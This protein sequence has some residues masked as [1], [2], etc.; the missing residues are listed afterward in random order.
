[1]T[2]P[3]RIDRAETIFWSVRAYPIEARET[4]LARECGADAELRAMVSSLLELDTVDL[5]RFLPPREVPLDPQ[6]DLGPTLG[7][8]QLV[9]PLGRGGMGVVYEAHDPSLERRVALKLFPKELESSRPSLDRIEHEAKIL[10]RLNHPN[11]ATIHSLESGEGRLFLTLELVPGPTLGERIT[12]RPLSLLEVLELAHQLAQALGYAHDRGVVHCD[13][14][15]ENIKVGGEGRAKVLDFGIAVLVDVESAPSKLGTPGYLSPEQLEGSAPDPAF[16]LWALGCVLFECLSGRKP[17]I[18]DSPRE[19][20]DSTRDGRMNWDVLPSEVPEGVRSVLE[21]LLSREPKDRG[22]ASQLEEQLGRLL[23]EVGLSSVRT[24]VG[25]SLTNLGPQR[26]RFVG[27]RKLLSE[28]AGLLERG[29]LVTLT[30]IGGIGKSRVAEELARRQMRRFGGGAWFVDLSRTGGEESIDRIWDSIASAIG[31][32]E[33]QGASLEDA[34]LERIRERATLLILDNCEEA[35]AT[36]ARCADRLLEACP[37]LTL[38]ATS[39]LP[40]ESQSEVVAPVEVMD[41]PGADLN[42]DVLAHLDAVRLF[43]ERARVSRPDFGLT[44]TTAPE[45]AAICR[46]VEGIPLALE[47]TAARTRWLDLSTIRTRL[48]S[49]LGEF[50]NRD[51]SVHRQSSLETILEWSY[52]QLSSSEQALLQRLS[53]FRGGWRVREMT[54]LT[55]EGASAFG[56]ALEDLETLAEHSLV[57]SAIGRVPGE[58]RHRLLEVVRQFVWSK[59]DAESRVRLSRLHRAAM[60]QLA[61][62]AKDQLGKDESAVWMARLGAEDENLRAALDRLREHPSDVADWLALVER[63]SVYWYFAGRFSEGWRECNAVLAH[64][65]EVEPCADLWGVHAWAG[66]LGMVLGRLEDAEEAHQ[67]ALAM[68]RSLGATDSIAKSLRGLGAACEEQGKYED[69]RNCYREA[70]DVFR[71]LEDPIGLAGAISGLASIAFS[72]GDLDEAETHYMEALDLSRLGAY[73]V[74]EATNLGNLGGLAFRRGNWTE[75]ERRYRQAL[76]LAIEVDYTRGIGVSRVNLASA[77]SRQGRFLE[78]HGEVVRALSSFQESGSRLHAVDALYELSSIERELGD[79]ETGASLFAVAEAV[80]AEVE[81][82]PDPA[83]ADEAEGLRQ[84]LEA[85]LGARGLQECFSVGRGM[86]FPG[87]L[88]LVRSR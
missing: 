15:P 38:V 10:A 23:E 4:A 42:L 54:A 58:P 52:E 20:I 14:K 3:S 69:A 76:S 37:E 34:I 53:I 22:T 36:V 83:A 63:L 18:G 82:E 86:G 49:H 57:T 84:R 68:A 87:V 12:E 13:L 50:R 70:V 27:R 40:L 51:K 35:R 33:P 39:R 88:G 21:T 77:L 74:G 8:Y 5:A 73:R 64:A 45:I 29:R 7:R 60:M 61:S 26:D 9:R 47:L 71:D 46:M 19:L 25:E 44:S 6:E 81:Y 11:I 75:A 32:E 17:V 41:G 78:A 59:V 2:E 28:V 31:V 67:N 85:D 30:G 16:D 65:G 1:M 66:H 79:S 24:G 80:Q 72:L 43:V 62:E 48:G 55:D 56:S